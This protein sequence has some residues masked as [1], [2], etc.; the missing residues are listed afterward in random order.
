MDSERNWIERRKKVI[1]LN[2]SNQW[3]WNEGE[4]KAE[5]KKAMESMKSNRA[6]AAEVESM[7]HSLHEMK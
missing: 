1:R 2:H 3:D 4:R 7:S 6:A 5:E